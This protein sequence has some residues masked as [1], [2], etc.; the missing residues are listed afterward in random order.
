MSP[1]RD[2]QQPKSKGKHA[3]FYKRHQPRLQE[4]ARIRMKRLRAQRK[5]DKWREAPVDHDDSE[6]EDVQSNLD[7]D[8]MSSSDKWG[9][10]TFVEFTTKGQ[11]ILS[12]W[13]D[14][15]KLPRLLREGA[16]VAQSAGNFY[17]WLADVQA[18]VGRVVE[19]T[20]QAT[21]SRPPSD[22]DT[23]STY[24]ATLILLIKLA[25]VLEVHIDDLE[26][27]ELRGSRDIEK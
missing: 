17:Q 4:E 11:L 1:R 20:N 26:E 9:L 6:D 27:N 24:S 12:R 16:K 19:L 22:E 25:T 5:F 21:L 13:G 2:K 8:C 14:I 10:D 7:S 3:N 18:E 15:S 23:W